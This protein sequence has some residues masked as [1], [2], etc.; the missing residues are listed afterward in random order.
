MTI[1]RFSLLACTA[2][3]GFPALAQT[4]EEAVAERDSIIVTAARQS[5]GAGTKTDTPLIET[6]QPITIVKD[7]VFL[8]QGALSISDTLNYVAGVQANPYGPDSRVDGGFI[9]GINPLQF[10]DGMRDLYSY[11]A[12]IRSDPYNFS[13][14]EVVRGPA[15]VLFGNGSIGGL[16]N[17]VSKVPQFEAGG[18]MALRYG[19]FDRKEAL[20]DIT[21]PITDD[22]AGRIVARVRNSGTQVDHVP[23]DRVMI[24]P[25]LRFQPDAATD[26]TLIGLY[27]ED[28]GG[29]TSQFLPV[30]G[31]LYPNPNGRLPNDTFIGKPG[32]DRYDG[33]LLQGTGI[34]DRQF[35]EHVK[36]SLKARYIDSDLTYFTHYPNS[37][38]N[39]ANPYVLLDP[40]TGMPVPGEDDRPLPDPAQ[41]TIGLYSEGSYAR[42]NVFSTDNNIRFDFDTGEGI[43]HVLLAGV[44]YSW[45]RV[46]KTNGSGMEY[47]DIY[48]IDYDAL[49]DYGGGIPNPQFASHEDTKQS[50]I[51]F[52]VQDQIRFWDRVSIVL[53]GRRDHVRTQAAGEPAETVNATT[54]RAGIIA[55]VVRGVS[56]FFSYTE[57]FQPLPGRDGAGNTFRP[58]TGRQYEVG[59]KLHPDDAT[60]VTVTGYHIKEDN[61]LISDPA[62]PLE[63][64]QAGTSTSKGFEVEASRML[65]GN[66][67]IIANYSYNKAELDEVGRQ[68]DNVPKYNASVWGTKTIQA[69]EETSLRLGMGVRYSGRNRSGGIITTPDYTLVDALAEVNW[70]SWRFSVNATNLLGEKYYA[71]CLSR[72]DCF[73][74]AERNVFGTVSYRF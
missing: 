64:I 35:G 71:A 69:N 39:P 53:G 46:R 66:Y 8:S 49:S 52:Y 22:I 12:S 11:Y 73:I 26:I 32:W 47:I 61:R 13:Q 24:A 40:Q 48:D 25:S 15:S 6:P 72:G 4:P 2:L 33:R 23:D 21:G 55:E 74:G 50:Q 51:G 3:A 60:L 44:D 18:E 34:I 5:S 1:A 20:A 70:R 45:N 16:V 42:M 27:Q 43:Q 67:E 38:S 59:I 54:F 29:S 9:R 63:Q 17:M 19:S 28:D 65:P 10:R 36:L 30:V 62:N 56:P 68:L 58:T 41:R 31:T 14:I 57:S 37:Y 7:D